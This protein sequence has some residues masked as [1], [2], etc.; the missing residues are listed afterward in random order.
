[1]LPPAEHEGSGCITSLLTL[2]FFFFKAVQMYMV[3]VV[4]LICVYFP[5]GQ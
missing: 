2:V 4:L 3:H 5:D 1:M